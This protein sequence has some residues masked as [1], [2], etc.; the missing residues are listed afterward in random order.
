MLSS[1]EHENQIPLITNYVQYDIMI[2]LW[3]FC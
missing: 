2:F 3:H 1:A